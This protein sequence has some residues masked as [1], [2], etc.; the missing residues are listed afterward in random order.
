MMINNTQDFGSNRG[1]TN[2]SPLVELGRQFNRRLLEQERISQDCFVP[3]G[4]LR[5]LGQSTL[6]EN[7]QR[8]SAL[9]F[10][11]QRVMALLAALARFVHVPGEVSNKTLR[12]SV[13]QLL[14]VSPETYASAKMS[15]DLRRLRLKGL[16]ERVPC[17]QRYVLTPLGAK[18]VAFFTKLYE[19]LFRPGLAALVPDQPWPSDLA[20]ALNR[21]DDVIQSWIHEALFPSVAMAA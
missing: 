11:D 2:F 10:G 8:A 12:Q 17:S 5:R 7:G 4:E 21:L 1:L 18:V 9:R 14:G 3:L 6:A 16:I 15:Y 20:Q 13:A 19:R